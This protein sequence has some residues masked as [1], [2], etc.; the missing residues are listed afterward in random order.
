[1]PDFDRDP[2]LECFHFTFT[3]QGGLYPKPTYYIWADV[4]LDAH[5]N[6]I[7]TQCRVE[8]DDQ[9]AELNPTEQSQLDDEILTAY[10]E[11]RSP[12]LEKEF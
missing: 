5:N 7:I 4:R 11:T 10:A 9:V 12:S 6:A 2:S 3:P 8:L 1:M